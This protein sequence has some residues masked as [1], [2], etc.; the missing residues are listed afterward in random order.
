MLNIVKRTRGALGAAVAYAQCQNMCSQQV[1]QSVSLWPGA[2]N[3][4]P[5]P[6]RWLVLVFKS[7]EGT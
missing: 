3:Q 2:I 5:L 4:L 1:V 6:Q 7:D